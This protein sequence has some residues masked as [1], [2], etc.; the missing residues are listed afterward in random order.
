[1]W[2]ERGRER[3]SMKKREV[4]LDGLRVAATCA[5]VMLH[6]ITG[7][8][9]ITNMSEYPLEWKVFLAGLDLLCWCVPV[10]LMI[11]G[12]LFLNP[13][14]EI[15]MGKMLTKYCRRI[16]LAL[17][18]FGVRFALLEQVA[19]ERCLRL[20]MVG[21]GILRVL[22]GESWSHMWYLYRIL[23]LY[24][25][26]PALRWFLT[27][28]PVWGVYLVQGLLLAVC[29]GLPCLC[30]VLGLGW[31]DQLPEEG[32]YLFYYICGYLFAAKAGSPPAAW[33]EKGAPAKEGGRHTSRKVWAMRGLCIF[34]LLLAAGAVY[35]RLSGKYTLVMAYNHPMTAA[36]ALLIF[37]RSMYFRW[38]V[39]GKGAV[40]EKLGR[41]SFAV[42]LV[43]PVFLN[44]T[45]KFLHVTPLSFPLGLSL[46]VFFI[47]TLLL[48]TGTAWILHRLPPM[49]KY[50]V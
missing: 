9:D 39:P 47:G 18:V 29:S 19:T 27:R 40:L 12:Y 30:R 41:L 46:P 35:G 42:Y 28:I 48:A 13:A 17:F 5:V 44:L 25:L 14:R 33:K 8:M 1:M 45:Y 37:W 50:V 43:H 21:R 6:T 4:F 31:G 38:N 24:L 49:R 32:I 10:F 15:G 20:D 22:R 2:A 7:A 11:S 36:F 23:F 3:R 16:L 34:A 26:T